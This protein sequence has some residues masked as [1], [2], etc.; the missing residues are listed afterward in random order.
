M[1][2]SWWF[3]CGIASKFVRL[4][5]AFVAASDVAPL[6]LGHHVTKIVKR[7]AP[8]IACGCSSAVLQA[9]TTA[10]RVAT[11]VAAAAHCIVLLQLCCAL[12]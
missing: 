7:T 5:W 2:T 4:E 11:A 1:H 12:R 10:V 6:V 9:A 8:V 3:E